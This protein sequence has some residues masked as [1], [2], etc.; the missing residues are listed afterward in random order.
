MA[1]F[2]CRCPRAPGGAR[3]VID[4]CLPECLLD[5]FDGHVLENLAQTGIGGIGIAVSGECQNFFRGEEGILRMNNI[6]F[7]PDETSL[8]R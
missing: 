2:D 1:P 8:D 7:L 6:G 3:D 4:T 5:I